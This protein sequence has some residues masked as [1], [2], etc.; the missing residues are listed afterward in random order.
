MSSEDN[1]IMN[2]K[3]NDT[4]ENKTDDQITNPAIAG[5]STPNQVNN[6][7]E[8]EHLAEVK[9]NKMKNEDQLNLPTYEEAVSFQSFV[10]NL[11]TPGENV[12]PNSSFYIS[13]SL[14][15]NQQQS[16]MNEK[17]LH[18]TTP[19]PSYNSV[20]PQ[21]LLQQYPS[22]P[23]QPLQQQN[24]NS[25]Y[26]QSP[27]NAGNV[28]LLEG[29]PSKPF[30]SSSTSTPIPSAP[31]ISGSN[32]YPS[33]PTNSCSNVY[34][35]APIADSSISPSTTTP[36][37]PVP[38]GSYMQP[39]MV[40][41]QYNP[42][43]PQFVKHRFDTKK[44][45]SASNQNFETC[46]DGEYVD[47]NGCNTIG[48]GIIGSRK[49][50][51]RALARDNIIKSSIG[52]SIVDIRGARILNGESRIVFDGTLG[53]L[54]FVVPKYISIIMEDQFCIGEVFSYRPTE[55][56][57]DESMKKGLPVLRVVV[58][59][60][61]GDINIIEKEADVNISSDSLNNE[62]KKLRKQYGKKNKH[63]NNGS[64]SN[65]PAVGGASLVSFKT[66]FM[67]SFNNA[68]NQ[69]SGVQNNK[70]V[71]T[72]PYSQYGQQP[73][74]AAYTMP[75]P[76]GSP[77]GTPNGAPYGAPA[78]AHYAYP[79]QGYPPQGYPPQG[80]PPQGY[81]P[82]GYPPQGYPPQGY[83]PQGYPPQSNPT[84]AAPYPNSS[85]STT[86]STTTPSNA[87]TVPPISTTHTSI[88]PSTTI[89]ST[90]SS[91]AVQPTA[92][93]YGAP[94][95]PYGSQS[96]AQPTASPY[97]APS[98]PY[99][100]QSSAQPTASPYGAPSQPYG[101]QS[102][103]AQPTASP[104]GAPSQP[105]KEGTT[106]APASTGSFSSSI[107]SYSSYSPYGAPSQPYGSSAQS[108]SAPSYPYGAPTQPY[109]APA[110]TAEASNN[111]LT[112]TTTTISSSPL[113][114]APT[115]ATTPPLMNSSVCS[116]SS[117]IKI[118]ETSQYP[119]PPPSQK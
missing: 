49:T 38:Q 52:L 81:S 3:V 86:S 36:Y 8:N 94:S 42:S 55:I 56:P 54:I 34:P 28:S 108:Y 53:K 21:Q 65:A 70:P 91:S 112:P 13:N 2:N 88:A 105:Q 61:V 15:I 74:G 14:N 71:N 10:D 92:S 62:L 16:Q 89:S 111:I 48:T 31:V 114:I 113:A 12:Q 57:V 27:S 44:P 73:Y 72:T 77:Y 51:V 39:P 80:Y 25:S 5:A 79:P 23:S 11:E 110:S 35:S 7:K 115:S 22:Q 45:E 67:K 118:N 24:D 20:L 6:E 43:I 85:L 40:S 19:A 29:Q 78:Q 17:P 103:T 63:N 58:K 41:G 90:T 69:I 106:N 82:Q 97:G 59:N 9:N 50:Q 102:S 83:P 76:Y 119:Y 104:Y 66:N 116:N 18:S 64:S 84:A 47:M 60:S 30:N 93:P 98:Q 117:D 100:S 101:S 33:A 87:S 68:K 99:G 26:L 4:M 96:S 109:G 95:Q 107:P 75:Q 1:S 37:P 46:F 32:I